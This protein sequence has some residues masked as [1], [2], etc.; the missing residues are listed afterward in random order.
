M[1]RLI[2]AGLLL[3][4]LPVGIVASSAQDLDYNPETE[5]QQ[6]ADEKSAQKA[7]QKAAK[8]AEKKAKAEAQRI[9]KQQKAAEKKANEAAK[10]AKAA[11]KAEAK[12][13]AK[14][15][16]E[17]DKAAKAEAKR[18]AADAKAQEEISAYNAK[19]SAEELDQK[20]LS[21]EY[22]ALRSNVDKLLTHFD[23]THPYYPGL[24]L[25]RARAAGAA[26]DRKNYKPYWDE[27]LTALRSELTEEDYYNLIV[28]ASAGAAELGLG[29]VSDIYAA[30]ALSIATT[31]HSDKMSV[32]LFKVNTNKIRGIASSMRWDNI[33]EVLSDYMYQAR[34]DFTM[35]DSEGLEAAY[36]DCFFWH[37]YAPKRSKQYDKR[38]VMSQKLAQL[39]LAFSIHRDDLSYKDRKRFT[40]LI[41]EVEEEYDL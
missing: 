7:A 32:E 21:G 22:S 37:E 28:E 17:A 2:F 15:Q 33:Q 23:K 38:L 12:R 10:K 27:A 5:K 9:A 11:A 14:Q 35:A 31:L 19:L 30:Q 13:I 41:A 4:L 1:K 16:K 29:G 39:N 26:R 6:K 34:K 40:D 24:V 3:T 8:D 20:R 36:T 18:L 25:N